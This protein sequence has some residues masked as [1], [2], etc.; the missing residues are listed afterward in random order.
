[1]T[2]SISLVH[3]ATR[4]LRDYGSIVASWVELSN[5]VFAKGSRSE[6]VEWEE[7]KCAVKLNSVVIQRCQQQSHLV[8]IVTH[9]VIRSCSIKP[10]SVRLWRMSFPDLC[11]YRPIES[12]RK[13]E[14]NRAAS[15]SVALKSPLSAPTCPCTLPHENKNKTN[16]H[17]ISLIPAR[18]SSSS[19]ASSSS[20]RFASMLPM[21]LR[22]FVPT[23]AAAA[24]CVG[25][26]LHEPG[27]LALFE[28]F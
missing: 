17:S 26:V 25:D 5:V 20:V 27:P 11:K 6:I 15:R 24:A 22:T 12:N 3:K 21:S 8:V 18:F 23:T 4:C 9:I 14:T 19:I 2:Q 16:T 13:S 1:M 7:T 10:C 28:Q